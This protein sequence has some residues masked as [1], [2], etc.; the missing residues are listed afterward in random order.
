MNENETEEN[1]DCLNGEASIDENQSVTVEDSELEKARSEAKDSYEKYL[2][3]LADFDNYK[4]RVIKERSDLIKYGGEQIIVDLLEVID[5]FERASL[6]R[7]SDA[8]QLRIGMEM[9]HKSFL[10]V[11]SKNGVRSDS[12]VGKNFDPQ[13][14]QALSQVASPDV[15][16]GT[17]VSELKKAYFYKDKLIR[18]GQ[19]VVAGDESSNP[20][21]DKQ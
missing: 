7:E 19:V 17:I 12:A 13:F 16:P 1:K 21:E 5:N 6:A 11:L 8:G 3:A 10:D 2:R 18:V 9:I 15:K 14:Y 20:L 4:K